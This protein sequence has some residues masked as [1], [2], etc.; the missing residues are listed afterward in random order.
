MSEN[1]NTITTPT[2]ST[3]AIPDFWWSFREVP[4]GEYTKYHLPPG[5]L[6]IDLSCIL[7]P[8]LKGLEFLLK[9]KQ[10][11]SQYWDDEYWAYSP[12][13]IKTINWDIIRETLFL[14]EGI[15]DYD[16]WMAVLR[17]NAK[18]EDVFLFIIAS[19][20]YTG[21]G[22]IGSVRICASRSLMSLRKM[23]M[24]PAQERE[25]FEKSQCRILFPQD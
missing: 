19:C 7:M 4:F 15:R 1:I 25:A 12:E 10:G 24:T 14:K 9:K 20:C 2:Q 17:V 13:D 8:H 6:F 23:C 22:V 3:P 5:E 18:G 11:K 21:F 16:D